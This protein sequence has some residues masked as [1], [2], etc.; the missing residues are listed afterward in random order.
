MYGCGAHPGEGRCD[1]AGRAKD[2]G[3][4]TRTVT[5]VLMVCT[6]NI[7]RSPLA[8]EMLR[9]ELVRRGILGVEVSSAGTGAWDGTPVSE[10]SYLV[11]LEHD[12]D[13]SHHRARLL[14]SGM[15]KESDLILGMSRHHV[16]RAEQLG[17]ERVLL[18]GEFAGLSEQ[19]SEVPDP[20]GAD[21]EVYR[22][23]F[24]QLKTLVHLVARR[25]EGD[26]G[27]TDQRDN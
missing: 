19:E 26:Q 9:A 24:E 14:T 15:V 11:G 2:Q 10:G 23:T 17:G 12:L 5:R 1:S 20:F 25:I 27:D 6:G 4:P 13:L 3:R 21:I 16:E 22:S 18:L 8:A 7:C